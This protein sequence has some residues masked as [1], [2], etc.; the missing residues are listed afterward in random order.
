GDFYEEFIT[1]L[2]KEA[3]YISS[4]EALQRANLFITRHSSLPY[5]YEL[6]G[7]IE[8]MFNKNSSTAIPY[9]EKAISLDSMRARPHLYLAVALSNTGKTVEANLSFK[10]A[11]ALD[12]KWL[13]GIALYVIYLTN[14]QNSTVTISDLR[15]AQQLLTR[16]INLPPESSMDF[17]KKGYEHRV[18]TAQ[19]LLLRVE[20]RLNE[21]QNNRALP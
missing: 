15:F 14:E 3:A 20:K 21:F 5:G 4:E 18:G 12:S 7:Y 10:R 9:L 1:F 19:Q 2:F 16:I 13:G 17:H 6:Y 8:T 11:L